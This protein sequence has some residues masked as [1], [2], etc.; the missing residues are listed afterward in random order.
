M[1]EAERVKRA[2][3]E[4]RKIL[5]REPGM[6]YDPRCRAE[7]GPRLSNVHFDGRHSACLFEVVV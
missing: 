2:R 3:R 5:G 4:T 1:E 6:F 7:V